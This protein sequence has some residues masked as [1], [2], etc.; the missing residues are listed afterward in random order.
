MKTVR[1]A[2]NSILTNENENSVKNIK[3]QEA[4]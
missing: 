1:I 4:R 2:K 3:K